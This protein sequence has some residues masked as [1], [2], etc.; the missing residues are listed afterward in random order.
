MQEEEIDEAT[1]LSGHTSD[2]LDVDRSTINM[3][4][5]LVLYGFV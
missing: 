4:N 1:E 2:I 5:K 3:Q